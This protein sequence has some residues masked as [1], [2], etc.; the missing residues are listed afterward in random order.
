MLVCLE[1]S[2]W[3]TQAG[4][5]RDYVLNPGEVFIVDR[6]TSVVVEALAAARFYVSEMHQGEPFQGRLPHFS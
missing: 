1:G 4:D 6:P 3:V 2:L 5:P